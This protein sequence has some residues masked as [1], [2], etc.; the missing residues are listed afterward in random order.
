MFLSR[1]STN[2]GIDLGTCNTIICIN[3]KIVINEPSVV[4]V[5]KGTKKVVAVGADAKKMLS[6]VPAN[7]EAIRPLREGVIADMDT[8]EKM[9]RYFILKVLP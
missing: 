9:I 1:F 4:A 8:T 2:I 5:Q 6:R 3:D 7:I